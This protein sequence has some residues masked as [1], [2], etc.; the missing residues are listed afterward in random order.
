MINWYLLCTQFKKTHMNIKKSS[1]IL[2]HLVSIVILLFLIKSGSDPF[3]D[4]LGIAS[5]IFI[6]LNLLRILQEPVSK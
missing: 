2:I 6:E 4:K 3:W 1:T 5:A